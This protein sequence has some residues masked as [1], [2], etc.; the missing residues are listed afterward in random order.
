MSKKIDKDE[1][2]IDET[3]K[4]VESELDEKKAEEKDADAKCEKKADKKKEKKLSDKEKLA[5]SQQEVL[6]LKDKLARSLAEFENFRRRNIQERERW[7]KLSTEKIVLE[8]CEVLDNFERAIESG[9]KAHQFDDFKKGMDM[10]FTQLGNVLKKED[11]SK[12][13]CL[14]KDFN[15]EFH[16]ALS[17]MPSNDF[18][19]NKIAAIVQN[20]YMMNDKVIR[21]ARVMVSSGAPKEEKGEKD[22]KNK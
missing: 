14:G 4:T 6:V 1:N 8:V 19:E 16:E 21:P 17:H 18:E 13:D 7:I 22:T 15:P 9:V 5:E 2:I 10:I 11:V 20:G 12:I 3:K